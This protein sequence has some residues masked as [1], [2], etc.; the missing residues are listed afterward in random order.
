V[1]T[2]GGSAP[3]RQPA[4][5][6]VQTRIVAMTNL[7]CICNKSSSGAAANAFGVASNVSAR[8][9]SGSSLK[10]LEAPPTAMRLHLA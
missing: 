4:T 7:C 6:H 8:V 1:A 2:A 10:A 9:G 3:G 5:P